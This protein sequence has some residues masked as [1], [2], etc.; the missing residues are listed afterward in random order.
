MQDFCE[1]RLLRQ[2]N[3][4]RCSYECEHSTSISQ[5]LMALN[6]YPSYRNLRHRGRWWYHGPRACKKEKAYA[7]DIK[8]IFSHFCIAYIDRIFLC[9]YH[10]VC[11]GRISVLLQIQDDHKCRICRLEKLYTDFCGQRFCQRIR[12]YLKILSRVYYHH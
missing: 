3:I 6:S 9:I 2:L 4:V 5:Y 12:I 1:W 10:T 7:K 11:Y 8:K